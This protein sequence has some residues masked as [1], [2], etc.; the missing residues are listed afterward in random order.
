MCGVGL[1]RF[2]KGQGWKGIRGQVVEGLQF[3]VKAIGLDSSR[4]EVLES[5]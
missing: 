1:E 5:L 2:G 3:H 4:L